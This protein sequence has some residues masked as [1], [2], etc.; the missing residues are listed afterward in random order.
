MS[1]YTKRSREEESGNNGF[2]TE[3]EKLRRFMI[4]AEEE[5]MK[6]FNDRPMTAKEKEEYMLKLVANKRVKAAEIMEES[7]EQ[8]DNPFAEGKR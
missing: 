4:E 5:E 6:D 3:E 1:R 8:D 7:V 2:I